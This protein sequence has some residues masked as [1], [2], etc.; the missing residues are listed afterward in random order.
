MRA[1]FLKKNVLDLVS[2]A[3][4]NPAADATLEVKNEFAKR[5]A[6]A[7]ALLILD[8][9]DRP[10]KAVQK[11]ADEPATLWAK[12]TPRHASKT[13]STKL[14]LLNEA[15]GHKCVTGT[16]LPSS[17]TCDVIERLST[18]CPAACPARN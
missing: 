13:T 11:H 18:A 3:E 15:F 6:K 17:I 9:G 2:G 14:M 10:L 4:T 1:V 8:L 7:A 16:P 12:L 5:K